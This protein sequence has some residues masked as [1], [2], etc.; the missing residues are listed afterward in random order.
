MSLAGTEPAVTHGA[1][2]TICAI[3][4]FSASVF[5]YGYINIYVFKN[6]LLASLGLHCCVQVSSNCG[7]QGL[8]PSCGSQALRERRLSS[9]GPRSQL[10]PMCDLPRPGI[11]PVSPALP[12][13]SLPLG[14]QGSPIMNFFFFYN[15]G[16]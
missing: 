5:P 7:K 6:L 3:N 12:D 14:H 1:E 15:L 9:C 8:P 13:N 2:G 11:G 4:I 10:S 16:F